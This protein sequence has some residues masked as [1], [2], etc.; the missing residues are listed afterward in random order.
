MNGGVITVRLTR[1]GW[2]T[3]LAQLWLLGA[4][5]L[6][7]Y[8]WY[9]CLPC[10]YNLT[11]P[12][13]HALQP[14]L[15][16][17]PLFNSSVNGDGGEMHKDECIHTHTTLHGLEHWS[18]W[19]T[20]YPAP[21][22]RFLLWFVSGETW[23]HPSVPLQLSPPLRGDISISMWAPSPSQH[24]IIAHMS[25]SAPQRLCC[26]LSRQWVCVCVCVCVRD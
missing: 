13:V 25:L 4:P 15:L 12:L 8:C 10:Q 26:S 21:L 17:V 22:C 6:H 5:L 24:D 11:P 1:D 9:N 18:A 7:H 20:N 14:L 19:T 23:R 2:N 3:C 16:S